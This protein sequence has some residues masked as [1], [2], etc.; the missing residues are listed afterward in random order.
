VVCALVP[1]VLGIWLVLSIISEL[2]KSH[3]RRRKR[4]QKLPAAMR[5]EEPGTAA[6]TDRDA[7]GQT[8]SEMAGATAAANGTVG[9]LGKGGG[10]DCV[11]ART[12]LRKSVFASISARSMKSGKDRERGGKDKRVSTC[13]SENAEGSGP[14]RKGSRRKTAAG[15]E[16]PLMRIALP[17]GSS[18]D[19]TLESSAAA[20]SE[21]ISTELMAGSSSKPLQPGACI[22][23]LHSILAPTTHLSHSPSRSKTSRRSLRWLPTRSA[24]SERSLAWWAP[25]DIYGS[26]TCSLTSTVNVPPLE[27]P[28]PDSPVPSPPSSERSDT[29]TLTRAVPR[30]PLAMG[31]PRSESPSIKGTYKSVV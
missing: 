2:Y 24:S 23:R 10:E 4:R 29:E 5:D 19:E 1:L 11:W 28:A 7:A 18:I 14:S 31:T 13:S 16:R 25:R 12:C 6:L 3:Q 27:G 9:D 30:P 20:A 17:S 22:T 21:P 8:A 15:N 26:Q